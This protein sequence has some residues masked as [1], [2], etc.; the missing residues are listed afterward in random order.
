MN[1]EGFLE[2][3]RS[4]AKIQIRVSD[5]KQIPEDIRDACGWFM[6]PLKEPEAIALA[7]WVLDYVRPLWSTSSRSGLRSMR[8]ERERVRSG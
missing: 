3:L 5:R 7:S 6:G 2:E 8:E 1:F 4:G